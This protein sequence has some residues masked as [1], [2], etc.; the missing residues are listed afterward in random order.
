MTQLRRKLIAVRIDPAT[1]R[2]ARIAAL[3]ADK[4][5]GQWLEEAIRDKKQKQGK[6]G[7]RVTER[8]R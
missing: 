4:T 3:E 6:G 8:H 2:E 5:V 1:W 7:G